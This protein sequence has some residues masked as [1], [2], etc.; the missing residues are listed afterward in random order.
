MCSAQLGEGDRRTL[1]ATG[2]LTLLPNK[3][4][5]LI[6]GAVWIPEV[7]YPCPDITVLQRA[8]DVA[9]SLFDNCFEITDGPD[10]PDVDWLELDR[11]LVGILTNDTD[12]AISNNAFE[13][14]AQVDLTA[15]G[16]IPEEQR[17]YR[18]EGYKV[19]QL[20]DPTVSVTELTDPTK[21]KLVFQS[22]IDNGIG[23]IYNW[24]P[25]DH[26]VAGQPAI[27]VPEE[28]VLS[29]S[30][31]KGVK[32]TFR[33][34]EDQ[35]ATGTSRQLINHKKYFYM[36]LAYA[37]N[38]WEQFDPF[39]GGGQGSG[40]PRAYLEGRRNIKV[41][42]AIPRPIVDRNL[43]SQFGEGFS[44]TRME[45]AGA[46]SYFLDITD[47]TR[48]A[49]EASFTTNNFDGKIVYKNGFGPFTISVFNPLD[50]KN[51]RFELRFFDENMSNTTLDKQVRWQLIN[52][53]KPSEVIESE[54]TIDKLNEQVLAKYGF[55]ITVRNGLEPGNNKNNIGNS[56]NGAIG[57]Q[58][59]YANPGGPQWLLGIPDDTET[60]PLGI[61]D[62]VQTKPNELDY[63]LDPTQAYASNGPGYFVP[64]ILLDYRARQNQVGG[65]LSPV[66]SKSG[67]LVRQQQKFEDLR[68]IDL[69][70]TKDKSKWSRCIIVETS[71]PLLTQAGL[72]TEGGSNH[73][74]IRSKGSVGK[75]DNDGN[76]LP[77]PDNDGT[78]MGWF[79]GYAIDVET[80]ERLNIFFG[81][82][83]IYRCDEPF[84]SLLDP[85]N[86]NIFANNKAVG[87]DMMFNPSSQFVL[88]GLP[89]GIAG[90]WQYISGGFHHIYVTKQKYDGCADLRTRLAKGGSDI[91]KARAIKDIIWT[92]FPFL[93]PAPGV[94]LLSYKDGLIPNDL[95]VKIR[96]DNQFTTA[97]TT[98]GTRNGYPTYQFTVTGKESVAISTDD[99][100]N[101]ALD[102]INVVPNPY[103]G[104]SAYENNQFSTRVK[105]TNLPAKCVVTIYTL[106]GKFIRQYNR[107]E[108]GTVP[109]GNN[110]AI[111]RNQILPDLEWDL[112]NSKN[113]PVAPG[114]YL[115][116]I[117]AEGMGE[118]T[119][120]WF[121]ITRQYDPSG[122]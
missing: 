113:I 61:Y 81:E 5:E 95:T 97:A 42:T 47:E 35:F 2:P 118:R 72:V 86:T 19:F 75:D 116:H 100:I 60:R 3:V 89:Q 105:I 73:F 88:T 56:K 54:S 53:D 6:I 102:V 15:P 28:R 93:S 74:E 25:E 120:K 8:D 32:H 59:V 78:G 33:I 66:W 91:N 14:Y 44:I 22:D 52:L 9:Q 23:K 87:A 27:W 21:A 76:G 40:Q 101:K 63:G 119:L 4:N 49:I 117:K 62:Y 108:Q 11:E 121:G 98:G 85:C 96:V 67:G 83:S 20:V 77:D 57:Y 34:T 13:Q 37:H 48:A 41:Y 58:E 70:F 84:L 115:I 16:T 82:A 110:R 112:K 10:A 17:T 29:A 26:P 46:G 69:V 71:Q 79:P 111:A 12:Q 39:A 94:S 80:G 109:T 45:G 18:F 103:Y 64:Y 114:I 38:N 36:T 68:S 30:P 90:V 51:G 24:T 107:D 122:L 7:D 50:V 43:N 99:E 106:D 31:D 104:F 55:T 92:G 65:Y 1:Q